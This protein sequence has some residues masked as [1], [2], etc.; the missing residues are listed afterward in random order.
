MFEV[1]VE[2]CDG[3]GSM[4]LYFLR[5]PVLGTG[6]WGRTPGG[7][8]VYTY[9]GTSYWLRLTATDLRCKQVNVKFK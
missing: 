1:Q 7:S 8:M 6:Q 2:F 3:G 4:L 9:L 5:T